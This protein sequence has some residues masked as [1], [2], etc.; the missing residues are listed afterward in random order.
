LSTTIMFGAADNELRQ[1]SMTR[2][3]LYVTNTKVT[4]VQ[5]EAESVSVIKQPPI[6]LDRLTT[7]FT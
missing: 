2:A 4:W 1:S 3:E 5:A 7:N 6:D